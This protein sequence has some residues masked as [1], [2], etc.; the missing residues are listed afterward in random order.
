[1]VFMTKTTTEISKMISK[2][3]YDSG[4][5]EIQISGFFKSSSGAPIVE[6]QKK[7]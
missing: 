4:T 7:Q 1:M 3:F 5:Y 6:I 2:K